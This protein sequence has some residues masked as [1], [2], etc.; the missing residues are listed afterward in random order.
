LNIALF[1]GDLNYTITQLQTIFQK[2]Y[3]I[4][5]LNPEK[6]ITFSSKLWIYGRNMFPTYG[7]QVFFKEVWQY[8]FLRNANR[9]SSYNRLTIK[10]ML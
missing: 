3:L 2:L 5:V 10:F 1:S 7:H 8:F 9:M 4:N 6:K